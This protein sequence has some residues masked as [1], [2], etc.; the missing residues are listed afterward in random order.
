MEI[1]RYL[2][3]TDKNKKSIIFHSFSIS[4][5]R[6]KITSGLTIPV[7]DWNSET[8]V[9]KKSAENAQ[10]YNQVLKN[11]RVEIENVF[12]ECMRDK[13]AFTKELVDERLNPTEKVVIQKDFLFYLE[14]WL[15]SSKLTKTEGTMKSHLTTFKHLVEFSKKKNYTITF[16]SIN[17]EFY[18]KFTKFLFNDKGNFNANAGRHIKN[19]KTFLNDMTERG[20]NTNMEY[21]KKFFKAFKDEPEIFALTIEELN[22]MSNIEL[23][24]KLDK[25]RDL[26]LFEAYTGLRFSDAQNLKHENPDSEFMLVPV[27]KTKDFLKLPLNEKAKSILKKYYDPE[28]KCVDLPKISNPRMN[29][30]IKEICTQLEWTDKINVVKFKGVKRFE[31]QYE[32]KELVSTHTARRS[33]VTNALEIGIPPTLVMQLVGHKKLDT[34]KRYTKHNEKSLQEAINKFNL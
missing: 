25:V 6:Y 18:E 24:T 8:Q 2:K 3:T 29:A 16:D 31:F 4:N 13:K 27:I 9:L 26:F 14:E 28:K 32:K 30:Y 5:K 22:Q 21:D 15:D 23:G 34:M 12:L 1:K 10:E 17:R 33:F 20:I 11:Q 7:K 19:I